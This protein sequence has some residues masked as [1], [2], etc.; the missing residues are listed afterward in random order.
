[1]G[2]KKTTPVTVNDIEYIVEDMTDECKMILRHCDDLQRK[3]ESTKFNLDQLSVGKD[4]FVGMLAQKLEN[5]E[6]EVEE[7]ELVP[8]A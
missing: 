8:E 2:E 5:P 6:P 7:A 1:M 4:A 3:I